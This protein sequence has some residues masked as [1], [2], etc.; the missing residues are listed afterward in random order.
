MAFHSYAFQQAYLKH[1]DI[2]LPSHNAIIKPNKINDYLV[3]SIPSWDSNCI[4]FL[5]EVFYQIRMQTMTFYHLAVWRFIK[6]PLILRSIHPS[7]LPPTPLRFVGSGGGDAINLLIRSA[8]WASPF[9][10]LLK[11]CRLKQWIPPEEVV[12]QYRVES[13]NPSLSHLPHIP[14]CYPTVLHH[15]CL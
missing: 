11:R 7:I 3:H 5:R 10:F 12:N 9:Y 8:Q 6:S 13:P 1:M 4:D 14:C 15:L 2:F